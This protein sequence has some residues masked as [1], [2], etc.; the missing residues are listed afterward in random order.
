MYGIIAMIIQCIGT[1]VTEWITKEQ[2]GA[3]AIF[4]D[5]RPEG[6]VVNFIDTDH[7]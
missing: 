7:V 5:P 2:S 4:L 6:M 1:G 3:G